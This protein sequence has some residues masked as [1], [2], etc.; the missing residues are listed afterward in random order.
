VTWSA[1]T[2]GS[3]TSTSAP[4]AI[5]GWIGTPS[6]GS[7]I[8]GLVPITVAGGQTLH[9]AT[10]D[11]WP[12]SNPSASTTLATGASG[13][14]GATLATLDTTT[15]ANGSYIVRVQA[16]N[17]SGAS[18]SSGTLISVVGENK[19]GRVTFDVTDF[20][21]PITGEPIKIGRTYDSLDRNTIGDF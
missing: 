9:N 16:T 17:A 7:S 2:V 19:P 15:L 5:P 3:S 18:L 20:T 8:S 12:A 10:V 6:S 1:S 14:P 4:L 13:G 11:F 21:V